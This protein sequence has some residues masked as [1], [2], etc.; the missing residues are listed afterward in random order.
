MFFKIPIR[1]RDVLSCAPING[2]QCLI[3]TL[4]RINKQKLL[5]GCLLTQNHTLVLCPKLNCVN[6]IALLSQRCS[7][8]SLSS[9]G[10]TGLCHH[11]QHGFSD[12]PPSQAI[13]SV[14]LLCRFQFIEKEFSD[15]RTTFNDFVD[16]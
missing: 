12:F 8:L 4:L 1:H 10:I 2:E 5:A 15:P 11:A 16:T 9:A 6:R 13:C 7:C 3:S 14:F